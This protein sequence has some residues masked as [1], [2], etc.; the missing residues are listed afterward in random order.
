MRTTRKRDGTHQNRRQ[1][2]VQE[3]KA[4]DDGDTT[5]PHAGEVE[6]QEEKEKSGLGARVFRLRAKHALLSLVCR[7][8]RRGARP[9]AN[10][11]TPNRMPLRHQRCHLC[12]ID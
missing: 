8:E 1:T 7:L 10:E 6:G 11:L 2:D 4:G 12:A 3:T 9:W 5:V